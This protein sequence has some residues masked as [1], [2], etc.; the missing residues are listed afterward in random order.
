[1]K[2]NINIHCLTVVLIFVS[3]T[4][5]CIRNSEEK[6]SKGIDLFNNEEFTR[7]NVYFEEGLIGSA[8]V[9][10]LDEIKFSFAENAIFYRKNKILKI[11]W[12]L[13]LNI[14]TNENYN[15]L[16]YDP[17]SKK[18]GISNGYDINIYNDEGDLLKTCGPTP[19]EQRIKAF[20]ISNEKIYY[21]K[22]GKIFVYDL[23]SDSVNFLANDKTSNSFGKESYNVKLYKADNLLG[24][25]AGIAGRYFLNILDLKSNTMILQNA[26]LA[27]ARLFIKNNE[28]YYVSGD[29]G[30][31]SCIMQTISPKKTKIISEFG[32]LSDIEIFSSGSLY[33]DKSGFGIIDFEKSVNLKTPFH[34]E[35]SG[36]C[37]GK[38]V[39]K[40]S[41]NYYIIDMPAFLDNIR[42]IN[43]KVPSIFR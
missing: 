42:S 27:S 25:A 31:Y 3:L 8:L 43:D 38:A 9:K 39:I 24:I 21:F 20:T 11:V 30:K 18:L 15:M 32:S 28:V 40:F 1:M 10:K 4:A 22:D 37:S 7:A 12:P 29:A 19:D 14:E 5:G 16:S 33:E 23:H 6:I 2:T 41:N 34:Y 26:A 36:Q 13:E 17:G 35:I